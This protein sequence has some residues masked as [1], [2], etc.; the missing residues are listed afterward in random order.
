MA[1]DLAKLNE[2]I[3]P[4]DGLNIERLSSTEAIK[5]KHGWIR[6]LGEGKSLGTLL[7]NMW[8][9]YGFGSDSAWWHY[10]GLLNGEP[11]SWASVFY[12]MGVAGV[13][14]VGTAPEARRQGIGSAITLR[15]LLDARDRGYR[16]GV[17][18][19]SQMG[20]DVYRNLGFET[21]FTIKTM[22]ENTRR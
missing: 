20:Y 9:T 8:A 15:G 10:I 13:Y 22:L 12:A 16:V 18:Q 11:V 2:D 6:R 14:A 21:C 1:V 17:L 7:L 3:M 5:E 19:S 4:P